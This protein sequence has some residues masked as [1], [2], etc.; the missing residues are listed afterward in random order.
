MGNFNLT[1]KA[2]EDLSAIW[3]Y[4]FEVWS[5]TQAD[6]YYFIILD[7][8]KQLADEIITGRNYREV[9]EDIL[10]YKVGRHIIFYRKTLP[11][12]IE[13]VRILHSKMDLKTRMVE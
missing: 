3:D 12:D 1:N 10:G 4:T 2:V 5:E 6:K 11:D 8:C 13:I 9:A 7:T